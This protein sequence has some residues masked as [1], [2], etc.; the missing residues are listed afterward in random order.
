MQQVCSMDSC[1][2]RAGQLN[3]SH[4]YLGQTQAHVNTQCS[5]Q[6]NLGW[7]EDQHDVYSQEQEHQQATP[8]PQAASVTADSA[9]GIWC[10]RMPEH[11]CT[12]GSSDH[13]LDGRVSE[14]LSIPS[15]NAEC[16]CVCGARVSWTSVACARVCDLDHN[17]VV[18]THFILHPNNKAACMQS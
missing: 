3:A 6:Y 16:W 8:M 13:S 4:D 11:T 14:R 7:L 9:C 18:G 2:S 15:C 10:N 5:L 17:C 12:Q 1:H